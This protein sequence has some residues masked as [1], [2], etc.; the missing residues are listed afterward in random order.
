MRSAAGYCSKNH[1][2]DRDVAEA[3]LQ[4][5]N[6]RLPGNLSPADAS[7]A[8][9]SGVQMNAN[10]KSEKADDGSGYENAD[11]EHRRLWSGKEPAAVQTALYTYEQE[12]SSTSD[13]NNNI[14]YFLKTTG[15]LQQPACLLI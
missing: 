1:R 4:H 6:T 11:E 14:I 2:A 13:I 15:V 9:N 3:E 5:K 7:Y 12:R 8:E 10:Q